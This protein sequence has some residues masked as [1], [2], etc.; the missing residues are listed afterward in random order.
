MKT[1]LHPEP[2]IAAALAIAVC[3]A[4]S[5][6][7]ETNAAPMRVGIYDSRA[8]AFA[9]FW[10]GKHQNELHEQMQTARDAQAAG[11]TNRFTVLA[12][13]LRAHQDEMHR[14][15]FST[16]P[17][18]GALAEIKY[19]LPEIQKTAG[20]TALVS[21]WDET[22]L[23]KYSGVEQVDVT[24]QLVREFITPTPEQQKVLSEMKTVTPLPLDQ[25]EEMIR[26]DEI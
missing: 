5:W 25:C 7:A 13:K 21:K 6:A 20:V 8:V 10:S 22:A 1:I 19:R 12:A 26:K 11:E 15:V 4:S 3:S 14:E 18:T 9:W 2:I 24:D 16:A 17:A 23:K